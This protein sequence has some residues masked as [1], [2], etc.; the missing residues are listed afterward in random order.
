MK[1]NINE[2]INN[3]DRRSLLKVSDYSK[4]EQKELIKFFAEGSKSLE[5]A[6]RTLW[7]KKLYTTACCKSH[8]LGERHFYFTSMSAYIAFEPGIDVFKYL[9]DELVSNPYI[10]L[11][12]DT[13]QGIYFYGKDKDLLILKFVNDIMMKIIVNS[14]YLK[15]KINK[16]LDYTLRK[17]LLHDYLIE[18]GFTEEEVKELFRIDI[19]LLILDEQSKYTYV[20]EEEYKDLLNRSISIKNDV[21]QRKLSKKKRGRK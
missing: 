14:K 9:S 20:S 16:P 4:E 10:M 7:N 6:L 13:N 8:P 2:V 21:Y 11:L 19:E 3:N 15:D 17:R 1:L 12:S 18:S 5:L